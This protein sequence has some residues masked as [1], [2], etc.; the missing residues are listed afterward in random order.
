MGWVYRDT[1]YALRRLIRSPGFTL[2]AVASLALGIGANTAIFTLVDAVLL[3]SLPVAEP[4]GLFNIYTRDASNSGE[5]LIPVSV[6]NFEDLRAQARSFEEIVG[7]A[8]MGFG[9]D[10][11][12]SDPVGMAGQL[13][14]GSYFQA[15]GVEAEIGRLIAPGDDAIEGD[16]AVAVLSHATWMNYFGGDPRVVGTSVRINAQPFTVIGVTPRGFRGHQTLTTSERVWVPFGMLR[17]VASPGVLFF[18]EVRRALPLNVVGRIAEGVDPSTARAELAQIA[19]ALE[20]AYPEDNRNRTLEMVPTARAAVGVNQ[21]EALSRSGALMMGVVALVLLIACANLANL[22]LAR[23]ASRSHELALRTALG[24]PR[25]ALVR[26][27]LT[28][29]LLLSIAGGVIGLALAGW[30]SRFTLELG[31][32]LLPSQ[33]VDVSL[34]GR[35]LLFTAVTSIGTGLLFGV[36]PAVHASRQDPAALMKDTGREGQVQSRS[37]LRSALVVSEVLLAFVGLMGAGLLIRSMQE[38]SRTD[39]GLDLENLGVAAVPLGGLSVPERVQFMESVRDRLTQLPGVAEVGFSSS[40]PL[41]P[42]QVRTLVPEEA[43]PDDGGS[44]FVTT[45]S[46]MPGYLEA[47]KLR[48]VAGRGIGID[49]LQEESRPVAVI[50]EALAQRYWPGESAVGKRFNYFADTVVREVVGVTTD[51]SLGD[52]AA[53][54]PPVAYMPHTQW[55][56]G[57]G[58]LHVRLDSHRP[59]PM[60]EVRGALLEVDEDREPQNMQMTESLLS[61]VLRVR[62][63]GAGMVGTFGVVALLLAVI[64]IYAVMSQ[65]SAQRRHEIG[66]RLALGAEVQTIVRM[67]V[68]QGMAM[69]AAGMGAG[70]VAAI[71]AGRAVEGLL[72]NV[73]AHDPVTL[74]VVPVVLGAVA[75]IACL[76]P[77]L[78]A[79][80]VS[81]MEALRT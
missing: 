7:I 44:S 3:R 81:P 48:I 50:N 11:G 79:T 52:L 62:R 69:V 31:S 64:G 58:I 63:I 13:V 43:A 9:V 24:A 22:M 26:Q 72:F 67:V 23:T 5:G 14:T 41:S 47:M 73:A 16:G 6:P 60:D 74:A 57:T 80:R 66:I 39:F 75:L 38:A 71:A 42:T 40:F 35:V 34:S 45:V 28:E 20:D 4:D 19:A 15:L 27:V 54:R 21:V 33:A 25:G 61:Q 76:I 12:D 68:V 46:M 17:Q 55:S 8:D 10:W 53:P 77:A 78:R 37:P 29:G 30:G 59:A 18:F 56:S 1:G 70:V 49:D 2:V 51:V 36:L 65:I 32:G